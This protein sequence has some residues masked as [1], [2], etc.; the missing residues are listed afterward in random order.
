MN[1]SRN[2]YKYFEKNFYLAKVRKKLN[3]KYNYIHKQIK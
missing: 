2:N 1:S 3:Y